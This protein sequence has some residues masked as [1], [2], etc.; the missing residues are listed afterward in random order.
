MAFYPPFDVQ[1]TTLS[2]ASEDPF[3]SPVPRIVV[4]M[5]W[6][7]LQEPARHLRVVDVTARHGKCETEQ[8]GL[9]SQSTWQYKG[10]AGS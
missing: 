1:I 2:N 3:P 7:K 4:Q 8:P 10:A 6:G 5:P 9:S